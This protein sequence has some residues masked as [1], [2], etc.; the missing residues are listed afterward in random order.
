MVC[1][2]NAKGLP[3]LKRYNLIK[4]SQEKQNKIQKSYMKLISG[5][6]IE[7]SNY[8]RTS[9]NGWTQKRSSKGINPIQFL[10]KVLPK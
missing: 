3:P 1:E 10:Q 2:K 8:I 5:G 7:N 4:K 6:M 9:L